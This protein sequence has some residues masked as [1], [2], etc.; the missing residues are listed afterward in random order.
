M[1]LLERAT[2]HYDP[3]D[4]RTLTMYMKKLAEQSN[5]LVHPIKHGTAPPHT[6]PRTMLKP[7]R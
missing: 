6:A 4:N 1:I 2:L 3:L 5:W 7:I